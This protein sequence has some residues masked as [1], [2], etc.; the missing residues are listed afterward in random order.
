MFDTW[1]MAADASLWEFHAQTRQELIDQLKEYGIVDT[2]IVKTVPTD[3]ESDVWRWFYEDDASVF[4]DTKEAVRLSLQDPRA[5][6]YGVKV[7]H[8]EVV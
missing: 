6:V 7:L 5:E 2:E 3:V 1:W 8:R 4:G